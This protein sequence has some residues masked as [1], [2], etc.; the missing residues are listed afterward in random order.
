MT[1]MLIHMYSRQVIGAKS[2]PW[3]HNKQISRLKASDLGL[4]KVQQNHVNPAKT[5][6]SCK[7]VN[8][9]C[10]MFD[11]Q[12]LLGNMFFLH[13][14]LLCWATNSSWR[15]KSQ[16]NS[17]RFNQLN[18]KKSQECPWKRQFASQIYSGAYTHPGSTASLGIPKKETCGTFSQ[19]TIIQKSGERSILSEWTIPS[20]YVKV[21][22]ENDHL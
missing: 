19:E 6:Y 1:A 16:V 5:I 14:G 8:G 3:V 12:L 13:S 21:A 17:V 2:Q 20:G 18:P 4:S 11:S 22:I 7:R 9:K 15:T 10:Q